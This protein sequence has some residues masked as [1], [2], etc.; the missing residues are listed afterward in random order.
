MVEKLTENRLVENGVERL[1]QGNLLL[2]VKRRR[3]VFTRPLFS[4]SEHDICVS[5]LLQFTLLVPEAEWPT[6]LGL[7]K[8]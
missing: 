1:G 6:M 7:L 4:I 8:V 5:K 2:Q 3:E